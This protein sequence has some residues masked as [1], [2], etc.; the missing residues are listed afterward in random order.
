MRLSWLSK[1][2]VSPLARVEHMLLPWTSFV[3]LPLF[4]LASAG[5]QL[6]SEARCAPPSRAGSRSGS[7]SAWCVGKLVGVWGAASLATRGIGLGSLPEGVRWRDLAGVGQVAGIGFTVALFVAEL[8][9]GEGSLAL[10]EAK[11]GVLAR[12]R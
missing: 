1:E 4:A 5:I 8:A 2:A 6:S 10:N 12:R 11:I 3:V 7:S 9:F